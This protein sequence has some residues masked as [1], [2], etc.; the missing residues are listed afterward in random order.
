MYCSYFRLNL[1][2]LRW[3]YK[4]HIKTQ[5]K[6]VAFVRN[7]SVKMT[8]RFFYLL[9]VNITGSGD[10]Y[11]SKRLSQMLFVCYSLLNSQKFIINIGWLLTY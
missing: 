11:R 2:Y 6:M 8:L 3:Q 10:R 7:C 1:K 4:E 9:F 5:Q